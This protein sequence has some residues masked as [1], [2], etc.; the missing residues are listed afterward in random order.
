MS[1]ATANHN[2]EHRYDLSKTFLE[3]TGK[4]LNDSLDLMER[5]L[6]DRRKN[7]F[8]DF[9]GFFNQ[10][11]QARFISTESE[12]Y[13]NNVKAYS[14]RDTKSVN[15]FLDFCNIVMVEELKTME[16]VLRNDVVL[17]WDEMDLQECV[18][19]S[20]TLSRTLRKSIDVVFPD[21]LLAA[22]HIRLEDK[23]IASNTALYNLEKVHEA[24]STVAPL[25]N[26]TA[27]PNS[28]Y[29]SFYLT[30]A[31]FNQTTE[32]LE[33]YSQLVGYLKIYITCIQ[34]FMQIQV[35]DGHD[36]GKGEFINHTTDLWQS[37]VEYVKLLKVYESLVIRHPLQ[38]VIT[39]KDTFEHYKSLPNI[40]A[41][42]RLT[43]FN[44]LSFDYEQLLKKAIQ[45]VNIDKRDVIRTYLI[46][47]YY[48]RPASK[49]KTAYFI[50]S[51]RIPLMMDELRQ[52]WSKQAESICLLDKN[53]R[54]FDIWR[55]QC[56]AEAK[57][58][59]LLLAFYTSVYNHYNVATSSERY[60][61]R[62]YFKFLNI[63]ISPRDLLLDGEITDKECSKINDPISC[64]NNTYISKL[65]SSGS[66]RLIRSF[67]GQIEPFIDTTRLDGPFLR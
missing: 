23:L 46:N 59:P 52:A 11:S 14:N 51:N 16:D 13:T 65:D 2:S 1:Y 31:L 38:R 41:A 60:A 66:Q 42:E 8:D 49:I 5:L 37:S 57:G 27:A 36:K 32:E 21:T 39:A 58:E 48:E 45:L 15:K 55:C 3:R 33:V 54:Y 22:L 18:R 47:L 56:I 10:I 35:D 26:Y 20:L 25:L 4:Q 40:H 50:T 43:N 17:G 64:W 34:G 7:N 53:L 9:I 6:P 62:K 12:G 24:Y 30:T 61:M 67:M 19:G 44:C 29:H 63:H 28:R